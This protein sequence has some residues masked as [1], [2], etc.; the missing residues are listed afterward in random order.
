MINLSAGE[1]PDCS[2]CGKGKLLPVEDVSQ[3]GTAYLKGWF[4]PVCKKYW[5]FKAGVILVGD[6][7]PS[8]S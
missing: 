5:V 2:V 8:L 6:I 4:C 1:L 3:Q 7:N